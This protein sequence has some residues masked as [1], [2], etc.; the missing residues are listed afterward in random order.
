[1]KRTFFYA[2]F[3]CAII[4]ACGSDSAKIGGAAN[5]GHSEPGSVG[6]TLPAEINKTNE[7]GDASAANDTTPTATEYRSDEAR[8]FD[9]GKVPK[10]DLLVV[11]SKKELRLNVYHAPKGGDTVLV[12]QYPVCLSLNK[13]NKQRSGDMR[14]PESP[15]GRP[16]HIK[17]IQDASNWRHDFHD[18]RGNILAYGDWFLRLDCPRF[19]GIGIHGSTNN[20]SSVPG[21]ASEGCI[22]LRNADLI[23]FKEH[24]V[25]VGLPVIIKH[26][27]EGQLPFETR[28]KRGTP[29]PL[30]T[31]G[32]ATSNTQTIQQQQT[33]ESNSTGRS[34]D[35]EDPN[36][37][38]DPGKEYH[39]TPGK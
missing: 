20:E 1:M 24:Y 7:A 38:R 37:I 23:H 39:Y 16:F 21:R 32:R 10:R 14:T 8:V 18:G 30:N 27:G 11:I 34:A 2:I 33:T 28:A 15:K 36:A 31:Q 17:Q 5:D 26:E 4:T 6:D 35:I 25:Y 12:A 19:N 9:G 13:G 3:F 29:I 22:R